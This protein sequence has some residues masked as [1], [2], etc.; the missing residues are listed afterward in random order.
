MLEKASLSQ[1]Q[2]KY[3]HDKTATY[4]NIVMTPYPP[5]QKHADCRQSACYGRDDCEWQMANGVENGFSYPCRHFQITDRG[6][7]RWGNK[8]TGQQKPGEK[9]SKNEVDQGYASLCL[10]NHFLVLW[11][12]GFI[13]ALDSSFAQMCRE[14]RLQLT[15][16][17]CHD[18]AWVDAW[19]PF[20]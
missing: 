10:K 11:P 15:H 9:S 13:L 20:L 3:T 17:K 6:V 8:E 7:R 12:M 1:M 19:I 16:L 5:K 2:M 4:P 18:K 14:E